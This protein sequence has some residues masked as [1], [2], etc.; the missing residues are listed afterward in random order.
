MDSDR[1]AS[2]TTW[3]PFLLALML[4]L[5]AIFTPWPLIGT[6]PDQPVAGVDSVGAQQAEARLWQDPFSAVARHQDKHPGDGHALSWLS[7]QAGKKCG[8]KEDCTVAALGILLPGSP[9]VGA[10]EFR[11]RIRYAVVSALGTAGYAPEDA[12]H[13]G[14]VEL[15]M[16][17]LLPF[18]WHTRESSSN[19]GVA[20][21]HILLL[22]LD[23]AALGQRPREGGVVPLLARMRKLLETL[24]PSC[25]LHLIGPASSG[26]LQGLLG[27]A[28]RERGSLTPGPSPGGRGEADFARRLHWHSPFATLAPGT[29]QTGATDLDTAFAGRF[30]GFTSQIADDAQLARALAGELAARGVDGR[31][32]AWRG[33]ELP[34]RNWPVLGGEGI[35]VALVGQRDTAYARG[36]SAALE[37]ALRPYRVEVAKAGYLRG[38]D[39]KAAG[40]AAGKEDKSGKDEKTAIERPEGDAQIDYLRRLAQDLLRRQSELQRAGKPGIRAIGILGDDYHDKLLA[41]EAMR[42]AIPDAIFFTTDLDAAMLHPSDNRYT[43]NLLVA[44]GYGLSL[45]APAQGDA[46]PFRDS[47]QTAAYA[48]TR[49]VLAEMAGGMSDHAA[50]RQARLFEVGRNRFIPLNAVAGGCADFPGHCANPQAAAT[51]E[52]PLWRLGWVLTTLVSGALLLAL[53]YPD[54]R[55]ALRQPRR[56]RRWIYAGAALALLT[57]AFVAC[58]PM[59]AGEPFDWVEGGSAWPTEFIR[60]GAGVLALCL[61]ARAQGSMAASARRCMSRYFKGV[62]HGALSTDSR[63]STLT[64]WRDYLRALGHEPRLSPT[65]R[66]DSRTLLRRALGSLKPPPFLHSARPYLLVILMFWALGVAIFMAYGFP[67]APVRSFTM[68]ALDYGFAVLSISAFLWL[69]VYVLRVTRHAITMARAL[70]GETR[71]PAHSLDRFG[72]PDACL[73]CLYDDWMDVQLLARATEP[74]QRLVYYPF[75]ILFLLFFAQSSLFDHWVVPL[76]LYLLVGFTLAVLLGSAWRLRRVAENVRSEALRRLARYRMQLLGESEGGLV[77]QVD[78]MVN[79]IRT[80]NVGVF[81]NLSQQPLARTVLGFLSGIS[82]LSLL[83]YFSLSGM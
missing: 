15:G 7:E 50:W 37:D 60:L 66:H 76:S 73:E 72:M 47:Y 40:G 29:L 24:P 18:E 1:P 31:W 56:R 5:G 65:H 10:E 44:S 43:R 28:D 23:E 57:A 64:V 53:L 39:G 69:L 22:W 16:P 4:A 77:S 61:L 6:R 54:W 17:R 51:R 2:L 70:T 35:T 74:V 13:I 83:E 68:R 79:Q 19:Q 21:R 78:E 12:E 27:G 82:G 52:L 34:G 80:I 55:R 49:A 9:Y 11:R 71:W 3:S 59:P 20:K 58:L 14:Y 45:A 67:R 30:G 36:L 81:A 25:D 33:K 48:T 62:R 8:A 42:G 26:T 75:L 32:P 46:P 63:I 41:L 38:V